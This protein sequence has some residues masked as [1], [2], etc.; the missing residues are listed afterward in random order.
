MY[1]TDRVTPARSVMGTTLPIAYLIYRN[2]ARWGKAQEN[3][4][5]KGADVSRFGSSITCFYHLNLITH[6]VRCKTPEE[7]IT[8]AISF[9]NLYPSSNPSIYLSL[10]I[11]RL[12]DSV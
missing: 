5:S 11:Q 10:T 7:L 8:P 1:N 6:D 12:V 4:D 2:M 9:M 3:S